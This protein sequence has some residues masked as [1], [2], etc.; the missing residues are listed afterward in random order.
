M[1]NDHDG[2]GTSNTGGG[3][4]DPEQ[5]A[6]QD[7]NPQEGYTQQPYDPRQQGLGGYPQQPGNPTPPPYP[8]QPQYPGQTPYPGQPQ[9]PGE[10]PYQGQPTYPGQPRYNQSQPGY[11]PPPA[12]GQQPDYG[13]SGGG[14]PTYP[15]T[16]PWDG[17]QSPPPYAQGP[18]A[19]PPF[20]HPHYT[21]P[22]SLGVGAAL[23]YGWKK[24]GANIGVW[25][26]FMGVF[27]AV[28]VL[29]YVV[30]FAIIIA[31]I[32]S[33]TEYENTMFAP[34]ADGGFSV[35]LLVI[36]FVAGVIGFFAGALLIRGALLELDGAR[37]GFGEF[38]RLP[39]LVQLT[40]FGVVVSLISA[41]APSLPTLASLSISLLLGILIWFGPH[42]IIDRGASAVIALTANIRL[43]GVSPG[44]LVL[45]YLAVA[46]INI[47]GAVPCGLGLLFTVPTSVIAVTY[48]Y[49][50]LSAGAVS[51][52]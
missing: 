33:S 36:T 7:Q 40:L 46:G 12:Y 37:P 50:V 29:G 28:T 14:Y 4:P 11:G 25:L 15:S 9:Y 52:A 43:L 47:V 24:F 1:L 51:P 13:P 8:G 18:Y 21:P 20:S 17:S 44:K 10:P 41:V 34:T 42:F 45:L 38:W 31:S 23:S 5:G 39:N 2:G 22:T 6:P 30:L 48:A 3:A 26:G 27:A 19:S 16:Q 49:R 32:S 35:G